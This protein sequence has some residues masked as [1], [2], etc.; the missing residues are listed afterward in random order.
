ML[1]GDD[2]A[3]W[4]GAMSL[5]IWGTFFTMWKRDASHANDDGTKRRKGTQETFTIRFEWETSTRCF[6][7]NKSLGILDLNPLFNVKQEPRHK[8]DATNG[9]GNPFDKSLVN[10]TENSDKLEQFVKEPKRKY[11]YIAE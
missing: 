9:G 1:F 10:A 2:W 11:S 5:K 3:Q 6:N 4:V 8:E 7:R